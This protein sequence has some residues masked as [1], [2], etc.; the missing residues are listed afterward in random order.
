MNNKQIV[1]RGHDF[2]HG[3]ICEQ[4]RSDDENDL[5]QKKKITLSKGQC[6]YKYRIPLMQKKTLQS[7]EHNVNKNLRF[8]AWASQNLSAYTGYRETY[9]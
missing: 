7:S 4:D 3:W 9:L 1:N 2:S 8:S 6:F 5:L